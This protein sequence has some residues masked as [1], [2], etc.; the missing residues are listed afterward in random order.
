MCVEFVLS[1]KTRAYHSS[2]SKQTANKKTV[3]VCAM[4]WALSKLRSVPEYKDLIEGRVN[5]TCE[6]KSADEA[7]LYRNRNLRGIFRLVMNLENLDHPYVLQSNEY[8][9]NQIGEIAPVLMMSNYEF[10]LFLLCLGLRYGDKDESQI[11]EKYR[12]AQW[13][14]ANLD[15]IIQITQV[16]MR[17]LADEIKHFEYQQSI[18]DENLFN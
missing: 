1:K 16:H 5:K 2:E 12:L 17:T 18:K 14:I 3:T 10:T 7:R 8:L 11:N 6:I 15:E 13:E 9:S 4:T